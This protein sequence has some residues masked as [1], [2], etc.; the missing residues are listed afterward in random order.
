MNEDED[1]NKDKVESSG[2]EVVK[3]TKTLHEKT[4]DSTARLEKANEKTEELIN[5]QEAL[6]EQNKLGGT[7]TAGGETEKPKEETD[8]EYAEK[9]IAGESHD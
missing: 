8:K 3:E 1:T 7:S 2:E 5:R 4:D 9:I 6:Y